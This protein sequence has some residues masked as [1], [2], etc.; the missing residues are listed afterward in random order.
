MEE[1]NCR[2]LKYEDLQIETVKSMPSRRKQ[3]SRV[4]YK[5]HEKRMTGNKP[6]NLDHLMLDLLRQF[7]SPLKLPI[8]KKNAT[9]L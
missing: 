3:Q 5:I 1:N 7:K 6:M 4:Y 8:Y 2:K 9:M